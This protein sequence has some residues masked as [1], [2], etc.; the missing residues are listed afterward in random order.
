MPVVFMVLGL[1]LLGMIFGAA[2]AG[3]W[4][5][6]GGSLLIAIVLYGLGGASLVLGIA[7]V[8]LFLADR[9]STHCAATLPAAE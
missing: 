7:I 4:L 1:L 8:S 5:A 2:T 6:A 3:L 9:R